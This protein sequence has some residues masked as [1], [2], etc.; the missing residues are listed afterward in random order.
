MDLKI[1]H[2]FNRGNAPYNLVKGLRM[3]NVQADLIYSAKEGNISDPSWEGSRKNEP[4]LSEWKG[5]SLHMLSN[6]RDFVELYKKAR[7]YDL[8]HLHY[9]ASTFLQFTFKPFVVHETGWIRIIPFRNNFTDRLMKRSFANAKCVV[10]TNPDCYSLLEGLKYKKEYFLP[11]GVDTSFYHVANEP[12]SDDLVFV[13]PNRQHWEYKGTDKLLRAFSRFIEDNPSAK[14]IMIKY[15]ADYEKSLELIRKLN[16]EKNIIWKEFMDKKELIN[17]YQ[18]CHAV[19]DQFNVG[20]YGTAG[21]EAMACGKPLVIHIDE[22]WY[23]KCFGEICPVIQANSEEE[24]LAAMILIKDKSAR[25]KYS[26]QSREFAVKHHNLEVVADKCI[27][28]YNEII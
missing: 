3:K 10:M 6:K 24:I 20:S 2:V 7:Q 18:N 4:W 5:D 16:L 8:L 11:F 12:E 26:V 14:L 17:M 21:I 13:H 19:F 1:L 23:A 25:K 9:P 27:R 28:L 15:G 22:K